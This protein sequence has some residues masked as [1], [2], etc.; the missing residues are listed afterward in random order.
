MN[1]HFYVAAAVLLTLVGIIHSVLG[2]VLIFRRMRIQGVVPTNGG[3]ML[4]ERQLRI[5]W[6]TWHVVTV[7]AFLFAAIIL[8][9][10][11]ATSQGLPVAWVAVA[12]IGAM[13]ASSA[14]V[15]FGT[16]GRHPGWLGLLAVAVLICIGTYAQ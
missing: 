1:N 5:V 3:S 7:F 11:A 6:A 9:S 10:A 4:S 12:G 14:F 8:K 15:L 13:I 16:R 2:E